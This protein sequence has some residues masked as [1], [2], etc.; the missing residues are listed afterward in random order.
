MDY[1]ILAQTLIP[2]IVITIAAKFII[3]SQDKQM[4]ALLSLV[5]HQEEDIASLKA[6][7]DNYEDMLVD[8]NSTNHPKHTRSFDEVQS[9]YDYQSDEDF[10]TS[11]W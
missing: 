11:V 6:S 5:N 2:A 10:T 4:D 1:I 3:S 7:I 9:E 8:I